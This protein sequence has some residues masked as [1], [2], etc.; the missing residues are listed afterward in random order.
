MIRA[1]AKLKLNNFEDKVMNNEI[2]IDVFEE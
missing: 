2:G 1:I